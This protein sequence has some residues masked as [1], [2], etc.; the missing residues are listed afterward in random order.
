[1][2]DTIVAATDGSAPAEKAVRLAGQLAAAHSAELIL[3]HIIDPQMSRDELRHFAE[4]EHLASSYPARRG[5]EALVMPHGEAPLPATLGGEEVDWVA[6]E[7]TVGRRVLEKAIEIA[8]AAGA[9]RIE[10]VVG[11][12]EVANA[13]LEIADQRQADAL[14]V[15]SHGRGGL[16]DPVF[17]SVSRRVAQGAKTTCVTVT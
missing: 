14:V 16:M 15:G 6:A 8:R 7:E 11:H 3:A 4:A 10:A 2:F 12:G 17:G 13:I 5:G 1:M 9:Q